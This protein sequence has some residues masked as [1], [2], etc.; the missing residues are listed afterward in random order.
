[1]ETKF[2]TQEFQ[3]IRKDLESW[4]FTR[5]A[6]KTALSYLGYMDKY[7]SNV[8]IYDRL[9]IAELSMTVTRG[10]NWYAKAVRNYINFLEEKGM[11]SIS[12]AQ[13][14]KQPLRLKRAGTDTCFPPNE[15]IQD[16]LKTCENGT[17]LRLLKL[18][19]YSGIR[20]TE[21]KHIMENFD[22]KSYISKGMLPTMILIGVRAVRMQTKHS[23]L[24]VLH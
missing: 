14:W 18:L 9:D 6:K 2:S 8:T 10:W 20:I 13:E 5:M 22:K 21:A 7:L 24:Q 23:C 11:I 16:K 4:L 19:L 3:Y 1:M 17:N 15:L 12:Q